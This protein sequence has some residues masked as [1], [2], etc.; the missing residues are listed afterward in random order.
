M[1]SLRRGR[2]EMSLKATR[3]VITTVA[4]NWV[5]LLMEMLLALVDKLIYIRPCAVNSTENVTQ[6]TG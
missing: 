4:I 2:A 1:L 6:K 3:Q 5:P